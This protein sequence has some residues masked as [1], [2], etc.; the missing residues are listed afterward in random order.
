[1]SCAQAGQIVPNGYY[2]L[3]RMLTSIAHYCELTLRD[4]TWVS[5]RARSAVRHA[6]PVVVGRP[7]LN[8]KKPFCARDLGP[9]IS[10]RALLLV[11]GAGLRP[12]GWA[13]AIGWLWC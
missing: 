4:G 11:M 2:Q 9:R 10:D 6:I 7:C 3:D 5:R 1:V 12:P 13:V 8:P